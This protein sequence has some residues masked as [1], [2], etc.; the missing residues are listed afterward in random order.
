MAVSKTFFEQIPVETVRRIA[1]EFTEETIIGDGADKRK[2]GEARSGADSW[3]E[4]AERVQ[5]ERDPKRMMELIADLIT[6][7]DQEKLCKC[8]PTKRDSANRSD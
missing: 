7:L 5:H 6:K 4:V 1:K 2:S 3:R 8:A